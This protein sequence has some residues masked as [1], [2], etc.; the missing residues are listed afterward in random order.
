[1]IMKV[2]HSYVAEVEMMDQEF[3]G[4][5]AGPTK[6]LARSLAIAAATVT[7]VLAY[8]MYDADCQRDT[9]SDASI[10]DAAPVYAQPSTDLLFEGEMYSCNDTL[11]KEDGGWL[12]TLAVSDGITTYYLPADNSVSGTRSFHYAKSRVSVEDGGISI[13]CEQLFREHDRFMGGYAAEARKEFGARPK[14]KTAPY[15]SRHRSRR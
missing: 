8:S 5:D 12:E 7:G 2:G 10:S 3:D 13:P 14:E 4:V 9:R 11:L 6:D 1:M 15:N